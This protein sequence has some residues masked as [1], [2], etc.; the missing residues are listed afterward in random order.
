M[1]HAYVHFCHSRNK[2]KL[3][4]HSERGWAQMIYTSLTDPTSSVASK[5]YA[6][7][8]LTYLSSE[9]R[10]KEIIV[11]YDNGAAIGQL[12]TL[13]CGESSVDSQVSIAAA[14]LVGSLV[15]R[16]TA[17][18]VALCKLDFLSTL[19]SLAC[20]KSSVALP[21]SKV[22]KKLST[23][24]HSS[25]SHHEE[26]LQ[27]LVTMSYAIQTEVLKLTVKAYAG[28]FSSFWKYSIS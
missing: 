16:S 3:A 18:K 9:V 5:L 20:G 24:I 27:A 11:N 8:T 22:L 15:C 12:A 10:N 6:M 14:E 19:A 4:S 17:S 26:L 1:Q 23:Y 28:E 2:A 13:A 7:K 25:D 21:S